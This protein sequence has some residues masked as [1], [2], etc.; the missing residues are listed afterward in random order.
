LEGVCRKH[1]ASF[2]IPRAFARVDRLPR[3]ARGKIQKHLLPAWQ[4][5]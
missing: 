2:K 3:T 4:R 5:R 1:L